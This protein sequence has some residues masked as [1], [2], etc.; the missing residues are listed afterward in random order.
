MTRTGARRMHRLVMQPY[1]VV[2]YA[3]GGDDV[4]RPIHTPC[5]TMAQLSPPM[6]FTPIWPSGSCWMLPTF[7][8]DDGART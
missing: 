2:D 5:A 7:N 6:G 1:H 3:I 8:Y 4:P